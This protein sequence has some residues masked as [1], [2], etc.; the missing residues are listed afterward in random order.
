MTLKGNGRGRNEVFS[1]NLPGGVEKYHNKPVGIADVPGKIRNQH[2]PNK[3][4]QRCR[5]AKTIVIPTYLFNSLTYPSFS[6]FIFY[7]F[8]I[9]FVFV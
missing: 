4:Q 7:I 8:F 1:L 2:I 5:Y 9:E 6:H 3:S